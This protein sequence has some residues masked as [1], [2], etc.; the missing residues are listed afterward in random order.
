MEGEKRVDVPQDRPAIV[1]R[2]E[3]ARLCWGGIEESV[4]W[5]RRLWLIFRRMVSVVMEGEAG[6]S[7]IVTWAAWLR[8]EIREGRAVPV[9]DSDQFFA[10]GEL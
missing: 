6:W 7:V 3:R 8:E 4:V 1:M 2:G 10:G 5:R 9:L